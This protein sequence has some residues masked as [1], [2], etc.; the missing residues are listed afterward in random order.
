MVYLYGD[1]SWPNTTAGRRARDKAVAYLRN[2]ASARG[3]TDAAMEPWGPGIVAVTNLDG[4][5]AFHCCWSHTDFA[6][7]E[8]AHTEL[9]AYLESAAQGEGSFG[10]LNG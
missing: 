7:V 3:F 9:Y 1:A 6:V 8:R 10:T 4:L 5:P 2:E